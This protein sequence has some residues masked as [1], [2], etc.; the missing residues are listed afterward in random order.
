[1]GPGGPRLTGTWKGG[2]ER[3]A[4]FLKRGSDPF[5][6]K[7]TSDGMLITYSRMGRENVTR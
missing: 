4:S 2:L 7:S 5:N 1:M 6:R 3:D